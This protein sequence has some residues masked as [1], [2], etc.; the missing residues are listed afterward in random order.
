MPLT[1]GQ[2]ASLEL[3][4][5]RSVKRYDIVVNV[6]ARVLTSGDGS[7]AGWPSHWSRASRTDQAKR[8]EGFELMAATTFL[9]AT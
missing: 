2:M 7:K 8:L 5:W 1:R 9:Q 4:L 6:D 3:R